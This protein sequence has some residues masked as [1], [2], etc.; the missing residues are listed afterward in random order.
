[1]CQ[2]V[3]ESHI[4]R[5]DAL[6]LMTGGYTSSLWRQA[7]FLPVHTSDPLLLRSPEWQPCR[8]FKRQPMTIF[9][10]G[11]RRLSLSI[12]FEDAGET[13][14]GISE[15]AYLARELRASIERERRGH[16]LDQLTLPRATL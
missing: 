9:T 1:M 3:P 11:R 2:V 14:L 7:P 13:T 5:P 8:K 4:C 6:Y 16:E 15:R 10:F 12:R